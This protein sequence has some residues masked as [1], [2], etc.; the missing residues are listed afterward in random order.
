M[1]EPKAADVMSRDFDTIHPN[2]SVEELVEKLI[3]LKVR[4]TGYKTISV[5]VINDT[6]QLVGLVSIFDVLFHLRPPFLNY[7]V[8]SLP[9]WKDEAESYLAEFK[10]LTVNHIMSPSVMTC[11]PDD[12]LLQLIDRMVKNRARRLPVIE[13]GKIV[14]VV[15]L[16]DLF[17][18][19]GNSW[20]NQSSK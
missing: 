18:F 14:G 16:T 7:E 2:A 17:T 1:E 15:Y 13:N 19:V 11:S 6:D 8:N 12:T 10:K 4:P 9:I 3:D 20:L 5:L